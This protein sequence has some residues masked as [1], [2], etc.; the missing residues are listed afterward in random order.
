MRVQ[1]R[2]M[3][4][5]GDQAA[6]SVLFFTLCFLSSMFSIDARHAGGFCDILCDTCVTL[7]T[8]SCDPVSRTTLGTCSG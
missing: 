4:C 8:P 7:V 3:N 5:K 2:Q 6:E 1:V